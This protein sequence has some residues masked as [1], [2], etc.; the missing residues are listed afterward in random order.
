MTNLWHAHYLSISSTHSFS[1]ALIIPSFI[2]DFL[3]HAHFNLIYP[4]ALSCSST[5]THL[6]LILGSPITSQSHLHPPTV[7]LITRYSSMTYFCHAHYLS[8]SSTTSPSQTP[9]HQQPYPSNS[10]VVLF[11]PKWRS[12]KLTKLMFGINGVTPEKY[13]F[14][15]IIL[16]YYYFY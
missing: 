7:L 8:I 2:F 15:Y 5:V 12:M 3:F 1:P 4:F 10:A 14:N 6:W 9:L 11:A 13:Q 16:H